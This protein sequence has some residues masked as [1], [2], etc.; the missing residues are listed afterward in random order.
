MC[1]IIISLINEFEIG[2]LLF[3][4]SLTIKMILEILLILIFTCKLL[5]NNV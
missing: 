3:G 2:I 1:Y 4:K 5:F